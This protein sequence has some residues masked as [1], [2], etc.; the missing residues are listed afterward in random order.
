MAEAYQ[1]AAL[2]QEDISLLKQNPAWRAFVDILRLRQQLLIGAKDALITNDKEAAEH[3]AALGRLSE[4][5]YIVK[6][7]DDPELLVEELQ[8]KGQLDNA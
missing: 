2:T 4:L 7:F 1:R 6:F 3:N 5:D 8:Q